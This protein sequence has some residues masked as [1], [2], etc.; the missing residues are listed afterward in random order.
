MTT[1]PSGSPTRQASGPGSSGRPRATRAQRTRSRALQNGGESLPLGGRDVPQG[2]GRWACGEPGDGGGGGGDGRRG[3]S[4]AR[5]RYGGV[6]GRRV[7][8]GVS[9]QCG[10]SRPSGCAAGDLGRARGPEAGSRPTAERGELAEMPRAFHAES[11]GAG[12]PR[13]P[14]GGRGGGPDRLRAT[15]PCQRP[16]AARRRS[17]TACRGVSGRRRP[18][19]RRWPRTCWR[20]STSRRNT[21][22]G[23]TET[24]LARRSHT[25]IA[26]LTRALGAEQSK[27]V[28]HLTGLSEEEGRS[29]PRS[30][31]GRALT[32]LGLGRIPSSGSDPLRPKAKI[33]FGRDP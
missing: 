15:G 23:C 11:A 9:A 27:C 14:R 2:P 30:G 21:G 29:M 10:P 19:S 7:L 16:G 6:G 13:G 31:Y 1:P 5:R 25:G 28:Y 24:A 12:A 17:S 20:T 22:P 18:C 33:H 4:R 32:I 26:G 8:D 3:A